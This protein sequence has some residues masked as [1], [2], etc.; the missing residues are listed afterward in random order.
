[1]IKSKKEKTFEDII[2]KD[3]ITDKGL[4]NI[5]KVKE[6][7]YYEINDT[8]FGREML[9][10]TRIAKTASGLGFGGGKQ[11]T[12]VLRWQ[13][14]DNKILLRVVSHNVV[15]S[16][17]L[18]V[19][20]AVLNSNFE[21][22][23]YSFKIESKGIDSTSTLIEVTK[24]FSEDVKPLGFPQSRRKGYKISSLN[25]KKSFIESIKSYPENIESRHVKTYNSSSP[26]SNS[27]TGTISL[28]INNSMILLPKVPMKRRYFDQRVG[29]FARSQ[30]DYGLD[31]QESKSLKYLDRWR[32]EVRD[33]DL[34][35]FKNGELVTP[36][37]Q[38]VY[39]IDRAT[40]VKWR[41]YLKQGIEDW[42][43]AFEEAGFKNAIIAKDPPT[44][45]ED[46]DWSPED[47]RYSV[48]RYLASPIP[49]A[50]GPHVSDP[51]S[52]EILESDINW[53]HNVMTLL[54]NWF[55]VQTAAINEDARGVS[56]DDEVM[57]RLIR[58]V[59]AH[60]V[61]HT[62]GLPHNMGSSS[63]YP[64]DSLRSATFTKKYGTAPSIMDY[65]R[66]NYIA[67][68]EDKGVALMPD[69]GVYDK[70]SVRWGYRPIPDAKTAKDEKKTLDKWIRDNENSLMHRFG[71]AGID[72]SSQTED[73]GDDAVKASEYGILN[74]KRII[75][76]LNK[77]TSEDGKDYSDLQ[78]M[79]GQVLSQF[80]RYMGHVSSNIGGVYQYYKTYDQ[81]GPVYTHV[82]KS[83]QK[84][85]MNFL[86][87]QLF[88]T[89]TWMIDNNIL[90]KIE[91]AGI[92][93]RIRSTQ[94]RTLNSI[95]DFGKMARLIENEAINGKAAYTLIDM[96][97]DLKRGIWKEL[98]THKTI[99]VYRRNLQLAYLDRISYIMNEEQ[100]SI[101]SWARG[102]VTSVKVSQSDIRTIAVGQLLELKKDIKKHKN[103]SD[104]MTK[105]HLDMATAKINKILI[106]K[107]I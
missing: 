103:R 54:R 98:Y 75:P 21:P 18:P 77:W 82:K 51:R 63:A 88:E 44:K 105:M 69:I 79:Y 3:A 49:N 59:S 89:P 99:D 10:V 4:F 81:E 66:F 53:Y 31:V 11:N 6:K 34:E 86:N 28:E 12:Q 78:T 32:L 91:F 15:A 37:K 87:D 42:Q 57:G 58:F 25:S 52:G 41:K 80:N 102:R 48:V 67:Q 95:L 8:L 83:H 64:V 73:L 104:K 68:P 22:I 96:M 5:H 65:A 56:F 71:S 14:K 38:I 55:F 9:M 90:N 39:Y 70:H 93:N 29:W 76:N 46:P 43:I 62:I 19:N 107:P 50:N 23:L 45:E 30:V 61:G 100:G 35:K 24:L 20:E 13:K 16:D 60:E 17:S 72:P 97:S 101:P 92:T 7:Y 2:T 84:K 106:G 36:K 40:P 94:S 26:P 47:V 27:S 74:L 85:C 1:S 33:E